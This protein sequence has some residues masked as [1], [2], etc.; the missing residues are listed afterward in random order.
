MEEVETKLHRFQKEITEAGVQE[1]RMEGEKESI[2]RSLDEEH[3]LSG[4]SKAKAF[5][6]KA[7]EERQELDVELKRKLRQIEEKY[8]FE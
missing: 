3:D 8:G 7:E 5:V 6:K 1:S 2:L 4:E